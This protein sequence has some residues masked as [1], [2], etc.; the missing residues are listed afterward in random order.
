MERTDILALM[1]ELKLYGMRAA[2]DEVMVAGIKR[3]HEPPRIQARKA[4]NVRARKARPSTSK[5]TGCCLNG[6]MSSSLRQSP[7]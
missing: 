2:Y 3:Q 7:D 4:A 5:A 1:G 6:P